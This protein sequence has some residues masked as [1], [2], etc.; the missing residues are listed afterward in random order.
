MSHCHAT[1]VSTDK[2]TCNQKTL[3]Q[4]ARWVSLFIQDVI[5]NIRTKSRHTQVLS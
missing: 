5:D 1:A 2:V 4:I 3:K